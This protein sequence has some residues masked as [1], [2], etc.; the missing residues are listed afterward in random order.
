MRSSLMPLTGTLEEFQG[1][2]CDVSQYQQSIDYVVVPEYEIVDSFGRGP[3]DWAVL[4]G[5]KIIV[6]TEAKNDDIEQDISQNTVQLHSAIKRNWFIIKV[7]ETN[8]IE[9]PINVK[10]SN[11]TSINL[12]LTDRKLSKDKL[13]E[14]VKDLFGQIL[15]IFNDQFKQ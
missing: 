4:M 14:P 15:W 5:D 10:I 2:S 9:E 12:P 3:V 8:C 11:L 1:Q 6:I 13:L 7:I